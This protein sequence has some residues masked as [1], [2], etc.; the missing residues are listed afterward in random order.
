[1]G[2]A[3]P[4]KTYWGLVCPSCRQPV[5]TVENTA[6]GLLFECPECGNRWAWSDPN[7]Q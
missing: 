3:R 2:D 5:A 7:P 4:V 6:G 1:M